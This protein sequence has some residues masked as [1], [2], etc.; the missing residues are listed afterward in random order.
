MSARAWFGRASLG[1]AVAAWGTGPGLAHTAEDVAAPRTPM[2][3][4]FMGIA[5]K[6]GIALDEFGDGTGTLEI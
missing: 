3:N 5:A 1:V 6:E 4:L 2:T